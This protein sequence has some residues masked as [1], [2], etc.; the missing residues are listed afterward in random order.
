MASGTLY[1]GDGGGGVVNLRVDWSSTPNTPTNSS[2]VTATMY[3]YASAIG[4]CL[5]GSYISINGNTQYYGGSL[6]ASQAQWNTLTTYS[7]N[8]PHNS[9]GTKAVN[10]S[11]AL[12]W[13]GYMWNGSS[14]TI[15][16]ISG[17]GTANLDT[18]IVGTPPVNPRVSLDKSG[19]VEGRV[20]VSAGYDCTYPYGTIYYKYG[21]ST[22]GVNWTESD[23]ITSSSA[24]Y[25][26]TDIQRGATF[27]FRVNVKN[28]KGQSGW[29][30]QAVVKAN[31]IPSAP[32]GLNFN[33]S[34]PINSVVLSWNASSDADGNAITYK[35]YISKNGGSLQY[36]G[37]TTGTS[38]SYDITGDAYATK[39]KFVLEAY[40]TFNVYSTSSVSAEFI[41][42]TPPSNASIN[43]NK[44]TLAEGN[45]TATGS[46]DCAYP[47]GAIQ[48]Q[49]SYYYDG[50]GWQDQAWTSTSSFTTNIATSRG[51]HWYFRARI[52]NDV[53]TSGWSTSAAIKSNSIPS[54]VVSLGHSPKFPLTLMTLT[55]GATS[56]VDGQAI[57]YKVYLSKNNGSW[58]LISTTTGTSCTYNN[59]ADAYETRYKFKVEAYDTL[60]VYSTS[61]DS[62]TFFKSTPP[63]TPVFSLPSNPIYED[64]FAIKWSV[65]NFYTLNGY[66]VSEKRINGGAWVDLMPTSILTATTFPIASINRGDTVEFRSKA[67]NEAGQESGW[68]YSSIAKRN[69]LPVAATNI[70]PNSAYLLDVI[71]FSWIASTDPDGHSITYY[72]YLSKNAGTYTLIGST[73]GTSYKWA[74]PGLDS[75]ETTY[76]L[77][78]VSEDILGGTV[79]AIGPLIKKP[80]PPTEPSNLGPQSGFY[81]GTINMTWAH[82]NWHTQIGDYLIEVY[83][84]GVLA[85][86]TTVPYNQASF[87]FN[88]SPY[89]RGCKVHY[90]VKAK[91]T[92]NQQ[93]KWT[94]STANMYYN[95][96]PGAPEFILPLT[97]QTLYSKNPKIVIKTS[98]EIDNQNMI[99]YVKYGGITYNS[100]S[101]PQYFSKTLLGN[102]E[103]IIFKHNI[104]LPSG[105]NTIEAYVNDG[106]INSSSVFLTLKIN[107]NI[108]ALNTDDFVTAESYNLRVKAFNETLTAYGLNPYN[109]SNVVTGV[110]FSEAD[111]I[112]IFLDG[113]KQL[114]DEIDKY[115]I[116][117]KFKYAFTYTNVTKGLTL[118][119]KSHF[120]QISDALNSL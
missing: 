101:H 71:N 22:D 103:Y 4:N 31:S 85:Q 7:V 108:S 16:T 26:I 93:S 1:F 83:V 81:E 19:T 35:A 77:K 120:N 9:D 29:S 28:S 107:N 20:N 59:S 82:S 14:V 18:V 38:I 8:V 84:D 96:I 58:S 115:H 80:T 6:S 48:Y 106:L 32:T 56:D 23:W 40:D 5:N 78:V 94:E 105:N 92:F 46:Y 44:T 49:F 75:G 33:T 34:R 62:D 55:W 52:K 37:S 74:I 95:Q 17:S 109:V 110:N 114:T 12:V 116:N 119:N 87:T 43:L 64:D 39:Y 47:G 98:T 91:N 113:L 25:T 21:R 117:N 118:I 24:G 88:L 72:L 30:G 89:N 99:M 67:V 104:A 61:N 65:S 69:K 57:T 97:G 11:G 3:I 70:L 111:R 53:G 68:T 51:S 50:I 63:S 41:K 54:K 60:N 86:S 27:R 45:V 90:R 66:Y 100:V 112:N 36:I 76:K 13:N 79:E 2:T 15:G 102:N 42:A 73:T 10:I